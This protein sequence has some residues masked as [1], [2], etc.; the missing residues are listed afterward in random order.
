MLLSG[1]V[2]PGVRG[3]ERSHRVGVGGGQ[4]RAGETGDNLMY[5][6]HVFQRN[7]EEK[8]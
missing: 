2:S 4:A 1:G 3:D 8:A 7:H 5:V 6:M